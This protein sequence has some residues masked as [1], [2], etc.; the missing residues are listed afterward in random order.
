MTKERLE[1][2]CK[3]KGIFVPP[4][5]SKEFLCAAIVRAHGHD[6]SMNLTF[7]KSCFGAWEQDDSTCGVCDFNAK[8][9]KASVG[10]DKAEYF[11]KLER[12]ENPKLRFQT[13]RKKK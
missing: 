11:A 13:L 6:H 9:F 1:L 10:M 3:E 7:T 4:G 8:C 2:Y 12:A 5:S